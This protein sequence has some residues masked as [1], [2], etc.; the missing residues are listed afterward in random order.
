MRNFTSVLI[1]VKRRDSH[2]SSYN[3]NGV[4]YDLHSCQF[5]YSSYNFVSVNIRGQPGKRTEDDG[6]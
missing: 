1:T 2:S 4:K 6:T 5:H 3:F